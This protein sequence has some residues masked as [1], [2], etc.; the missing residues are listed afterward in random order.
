MDTSI[1][2]RKRFLPFLQSQKNKI[3]FKIINIYLIIGVGS[4]LVTMFYLIVHLNQSDIIIGYCI[5][6]FILGVSSGAFYFIGYQSV[7]SEQQAKRNK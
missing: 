1:I 7:I 5:P 4:L 6:G 2:N 3:L